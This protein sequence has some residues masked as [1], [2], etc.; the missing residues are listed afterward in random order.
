VK[1]KKLKFVKLSP[2]LLKYS[3]SGG[4]SFK[5]DEEINGL[6][7]KLGHS[8]NQIDVMSK[9]TYVKVL[10]KYV[11]YPNKKEEDVKLKLKKENYTCVF[12]ISK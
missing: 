4:A 10:D 1:Q 9:H 6:D 8:N 5:K 2:E 7:K 3:S 11:N 12:F